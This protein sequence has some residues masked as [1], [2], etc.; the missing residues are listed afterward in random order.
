MLSRLSTGDARSQSR[1]AVAWSPMR[2]RQIDGRAFLFVGMTLFAMKFAIDRAVATL[3]FGRGWSLLNYLVPTEAYTL[4]S[5]PGDERAFFLTMTGVAVPFVIVGLIVTARRLR[6]AGLPVA[7]LVL[8]FVPVCNLLFFATLGV[9]PSR[10]VGVVGA[11]ASADLPARAVVAEARPAEAGTPVVPLA[12]PVDYATPTRGRLTRRWPA[13]AGLSFLASAMLAGLLAPIFVLL[14][15]VFLRQYGWGLFIG[16]P[17]VVGMVAA[18]LHNLGGRRM[19]GESIGVALAAGAVG[20][21]GTVLFALEGAVCLVMLVPLA[22]P[23]VIVGGVAGRS[24]ADAARGSIG[25]VAGV[26]LAT[27]PLLMGVER[28]D[29]RVPHVYVATTSID[30]AAA[31]EVV[32]QHVVVFG[33]APPPRGWFFATGVAYPIRARIEG[34]GVGAVRYCEFS[35]GPFVEPITAWDEPRLLKFDVTHNPPPLREWSPYRIAP[36]HLEDLLKS[37]GGQFRLIDLGGGRTRVEGTTWYE[38]GLWPEAYWSWW[39]DY[40][41][42]RIHGRVL[43]HVKALSEGKP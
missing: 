3:A 23:L 35:T 8:F 13:S 14:G 31:P 25:G 24:I 20:F 10:R 39:S 2:D 40:V 42:H 9:I 38:H 6:D 7:M 5:L 18:L 29:R 43:E 15:V 11:S 16:M 4:P 34:S 36:P 37:H 19:T 26:L 32:W 33:E 17:F 21:V 22:A 41:I 12:E 30:I 1:R 28:L 27:L